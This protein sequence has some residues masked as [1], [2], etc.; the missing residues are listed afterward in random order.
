MSHQS[1]E[2]IGTIEIATSDLDC[3]GELKLTQR[4]SPQRRASS[5]KGAKA[6]TKQKSGTGTGTGTHDMNYKV[7]IDERI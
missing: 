7:N 6:P 5:P 3:K 2:T 4:A 1:N